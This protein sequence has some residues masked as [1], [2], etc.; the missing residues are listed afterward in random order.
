MDTSGIEAR[1]SALTFGDDFDEVMAKLESEIVGNKRTN[2]REIRGLI[3]RSKVR[4]S[5][6]LTGTPGTQ[7]SQGAA[8]APGAAGATGPDGIPGPSPDGPQ[9]P[10]GVDGVDG[11]TGDTGAAGAQGT[12]GAA[13]ADG[14]DGNTGATGAAGAQGIPGVPDGVD[15]VDGAPGATGAT[16]AT[17]AQGT[18]GAD[19]VDGNTGATGAAGAQ[20]IPGVPDGVDGVDGAPGATGGTGAQGIPGAAGADGVDG[21]TGATGAAGATGAQGSTGAVGADGDA[22]SAGADS[23][24]AG[25][26]GAT[27]AD[28]ARGAFLSTLEYT[29]VAAVQ[30]ITL[31]PLAVKDF[32]EIRP[33]LSSSAITS[34]GMS[35]LSTG[36]GGRGS[37]TNTVTNNHWVHQITCG[38]TANDERSISGAASNLPIASNDA[39]WAYSSSIGTNGLSS[40]RVFNGLASAQN[41]FVSSTVCRIGLLYDPAVGAN[42]FLVYR[43]QSGVEQSVDTT[44]VFSNG[45]LNHFSIHKLPGSDLIYYKLWRY[46]R[47][48]TPTNIVSGSWQPTA[49]TGSHVRVTPTVTLQ[50]TTSSARNA[51]F[52]K[53]HLEY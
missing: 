23:V 18:P 42:L 34:F 39:F 25:A 29:R 37:T 51:S 7:G 50:V 10:A 15:G 8:G 43:L 26:T 24:I 2:K 16:G 12:P 40:L 11:D 28:G 31:S 46:F 53:M 20:G 47:T 13:G 21:N 38:T 3:A 52:N 33:M 1:L 32:V 4:I 44:S 36:T 6:G 35:L 19:G 17:G 49:P 27:G 5:Q 30:L 45:N 22:G 14:V 41:L 48:G 9:G